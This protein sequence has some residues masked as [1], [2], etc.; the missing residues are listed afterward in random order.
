MPSIPLSFLI[1]VGQ[2]VIGGIKNNILGTDSSG[3]LKSYPFAGYQFRPRG[4]RFPGT[5]GVGL[6]VG[7]AGSPGTS[8]FSIFTRF[9]VQP[10]YTG[11]TV[12]PL[13]GIASSGSTSIAA[14]S[15][16]VMIDGSG[17]L[18]ARLY[19]AT[20]GEYIEKRYPA[21][22]LVANW[23]GQLVDVHVVVDRAVPNCYIYI[24]GALVETTE[25][26]LGSATAWSD[27]CTGGNVVIGYQNTASAY[28]ANLFT[29]CRI[30]SGA[31]TA[32]DVLAEHMLGDVQQSSKVGAAALGGT[33]GLVIDLCIEESDPTIA[34]KCFDKS[35]NA[36]HGDF[37]G[38][39]TFP[40]GQSS[41][42]EGL[43][44]LHM[45]VQGRQQHIVTTSGAGS[46]TLGNGMI[47]VFT[48]T[49][50]TWM[51]PALAAYPSQV[52]IVKNQGSGDV[53]LDG[54]GSE[55][56]YASSAT[57]TLTMSP[58]QS[59]ILVNNGSNWSVI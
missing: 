4:V 40:V 36:F 20:T 19:G 50:S 8:S 23:G 22:T 49:T 57:L 48:G 5:A 42:W 7:A 25:G 2:L 1:R 38:T 59:Y 17:Q 32:A 11:S 15:F 41:R 12:Y 13:T 55:T 54:S 29:G 53:I 28:G 47:Y 43:K 18:V 44:I 51:L 58:G 14:R 10:G 3:N 34:L 35:L 30:Y 31:L 9:L 24:N 56:I 26:S 27:S 21:A 46:L 45:A 39:W 16:H 6:Q 37:I 52:F 33:N